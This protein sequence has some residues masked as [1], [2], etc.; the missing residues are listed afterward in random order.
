MKAKQELR[1]IASHLKNLMT[2][3]HEMGFDPPL[4]SKDK[5]KP[6]IQ[7]PVDKLQTGSSFEHVYSLEGLKDYMGNCKRCKLFKNRSN[8]V[9][10]EGSPEARLVFVGE[11]PG[12]DEDLAGRPFVG[13]A[14]KLL[15]RIIE[16]GM[17]L[18]RQDVYICNVVKCRPPGN[19]D[20]EIDEIQACIPFLKRQLSIIRPEVICTLGRVSGRLLLGENFKVSRDR[21]KWSS[22]MGIHVMPTFHPAYLLRNPTKEH[23]LKGL[24][25]KDVQL[26]MRRLGLEVKNNE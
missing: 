21:G 14:G 22:F 19:R 8:I 6:Q 4:I 1:E 17:K 2:A 18:K 5:L 7:T 24:V 3:Y 12:H 9:F 25:W 15:T 11:G 10:G 20:P 16:L 26:I 13:E 23:H